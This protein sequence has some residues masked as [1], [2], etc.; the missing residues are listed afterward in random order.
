MGLGIE[1]SDKFLQLWRSVFN[2][3][4]YEQNKRIEII[5][6]AKEL[7]S[8]VPRLSRDE[9]FLNALDTLLEKYYPGCKMTGVT[10]TNSMEPSIDSGHQVV[11]IPFK[12]KTN[13]DNSELDKKS[14]QEGDIVWFHRMSDGSPNVLHRVIKKNEGWIV[15]R[16]DNTVTLDGPTINQ[17]IKGFCGMIIY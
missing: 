8:P 10:D 4:L 11:L 16:G 7:P 1:F 5:E 14:I 6:E 12:D 3:E 9:D 17:N 13:F 15:T 2:K